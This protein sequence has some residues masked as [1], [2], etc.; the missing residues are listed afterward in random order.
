MNSDELKYYNLDLSMVIATSLG[1]QLTCFE[2]EHI[3]PSRDPIP[4][5][6]V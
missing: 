2:N 4:P 3:I 6:P 1:L 5:S